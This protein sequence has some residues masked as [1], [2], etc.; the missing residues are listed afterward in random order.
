MTAAI[1][2]IQLK[3]D[4]IETLLVA[5]MPTRNIKRSMQHFTEQDE[6][7]LL[8]GIVTIVNAGESGFKNQLGMV[9][10]EGTAAV[11]LIG[12]VKV[13]EDTPSQNIET[14]ELALSK[15][16][17]AAIR[18]GVPGIG[19]ALERIEY[20]RQLE[21]PYGWFVAFLNAGPPLETLY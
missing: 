20:S 11:W 6:T 8:S 13:A 4:A 1:N 3:L 17:K 21:H 10:K 16:L 9:A 12:H 18:V 5:Q 19:F 2:D 14:A 15:E 7:E